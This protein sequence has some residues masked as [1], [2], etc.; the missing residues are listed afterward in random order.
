MTR[1]EMS[2]QFAD[3]LEIERVRIGL[4]QKQMAEKLEMSLS[5]YKRIITYDTEKIDLYLIYKLYKLTGKLAYEFTDI[6][7][8][9]LSVK[10]KLMGLSF[11]QLSYVE[12]IID[13]E[14]AFKDSHADF[15]DYITVYIPT[16]NMEDGMIYD[17]ANIKKLRVPDFRSKYGIKVSCGV[18]VTS[19]HLHPVYNKGDIILITKRPIR[20]GDTGIFFN[21]ENGCVYI[22]KFYQTSPCRLEP[23]N[24]YGEAFYVDSNN[25]KDM[26]KWIKFG[27]II[28]KLRID[29]DI[30]DD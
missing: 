25:K 11:S 17:S 15:E 5:A 16:G 7:D 12:A 19:N 9:Y 14:N 20:D 13:F 24:E 1:M 18:Q 8:P 30:L 10:K 28:S 2:K 26:D 22:R 3:N 23:I 6:T 27:T 4:T 21:R 29:K